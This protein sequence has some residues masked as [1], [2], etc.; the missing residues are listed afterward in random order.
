MTKTCQIKVPGICVGDED[1][2]LFH[3]RLNGHCGKGIQIDDDLGSWSCKACKTIC[4]E[5][6]HLKGFDREHLKRLHAEGVLKTL[7]YKK[8]LISI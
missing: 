8:T 4:E 1:I 2:I 3:Y 5:R 6:V 7:M